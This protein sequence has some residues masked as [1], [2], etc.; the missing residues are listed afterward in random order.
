MEDFVE[1]YLFNYSGCLMI[2]PTLPKGGSVDAT[3][4]IWE[5]EVGVLERTYMGH[6]HSVLTTVGLM[7]GVRQ[8]I[9]N[10]DVC[11]LPPPKL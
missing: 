2:G 3:V 5:A 4:R 11:S 7:E 6:Y 1:I 10:V 8:T 9:R